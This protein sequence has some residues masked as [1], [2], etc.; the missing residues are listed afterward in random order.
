MMVAPNLDINY[1][2]N[3]YAAA[4]GLQRL[5]PKIM[6]YIKQHCDRNIFP[7]SW[8]NLTIQTLL[9]NL[10]FSE[11]VEIWHDLLDTEISIE[12][13]QI[14]F[15]SLLECGQTAKLTEVQGLGHFKILKDQETIDRICTEL[16]I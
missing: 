6:Q 9:H 5:I 15:Q 3:E 14:V 10:N 7:G 16:V 2:L 1:L 12:T 4:F 13:N 8:E 11:E